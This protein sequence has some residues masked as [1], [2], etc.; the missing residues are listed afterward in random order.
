M[1]QSIR[2]QLFFNA[3]NGDFYHKLL[4]TAYKYTK[5]VWLKVFTGKLF[6]I[7]HKTIG[8]EKQCN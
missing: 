3:I 7:Q 2:I 4:K 1:L 5:Y 8:L 6:Y